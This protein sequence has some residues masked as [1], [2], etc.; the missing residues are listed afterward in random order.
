MARVLRTPRARTDLGEIWAWVAQDSVERADAQLRRIAAV[1]ER[2][3][4]EPLMGRDRSALLPRLRSFPVGS[5]VV[6]YRPSTEGIEIIRV[7]HGAREV[8]R[9]FRR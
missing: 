7:L 9:S 5:W 3:A 8:S 6:Y 4:D 1:C 2:L